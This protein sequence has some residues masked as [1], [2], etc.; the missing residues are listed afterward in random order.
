MLGIVYWRLY[1]INFEVLF[2]VR[3]KSSSSMGIVFL[4]AFV[5]TCI[6]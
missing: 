6:K 2:S 1:E 3:P 5:Q 4:P